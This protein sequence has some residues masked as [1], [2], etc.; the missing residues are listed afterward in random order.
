MCT[1]RRL[2]TADAGERAIPVPSDVIHYAVE[3]KHAFP[4]EPNRQ[5]T[6]KYDRQNS[7]MF[8]APQLSAKALCSPGR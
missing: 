5:R 2:A 8:A 3:A 1:P 6:G 4:G 7:G